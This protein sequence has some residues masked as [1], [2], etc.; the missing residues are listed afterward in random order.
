MSRWSNISIRKSQ[1]K[2]ANTSQH[3]WIPCKPTCNKEKGISR[4]DEFEWLN[5]KH[6]SEM[7][8]AFRSQDK[9][10]RSSIL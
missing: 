8:T 10:Q 9:F 2:M 6:S 7:V 4:H 5:S 3:T 1:K